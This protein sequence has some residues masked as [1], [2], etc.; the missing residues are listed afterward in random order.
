MKGR[1]CMCIIVGC[2]CLSIPIKIEDIPSVELAEIC[3]DA[4]VCGCTP[5]VEHIMRGSEGDFFASRLVVFSNIL[6]W[7]KIILFCCEQFFRDSFESETRIG[8][9]HEVEKLAFSFA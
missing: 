7:F 3:H 6:A 2:F 4:P 9:D 8:L 5:V 1:N